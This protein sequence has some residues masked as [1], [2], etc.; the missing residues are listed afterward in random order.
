MQQN[1]INGLKVS[2]AIISSLNNCDPI[3]TEMAP[4]KA[5]DMQNMFCKIF[6]LDV[7]KF[8]AM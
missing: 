1:P 8:I 4:F 7:Q 2:D 3:I 5:K 6:L